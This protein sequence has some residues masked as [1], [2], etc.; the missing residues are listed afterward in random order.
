MRRLRASLPRWR[1]LYKEVSAQNNGYKTLGL[2]VPLDE[3]E[4][5]AVHVW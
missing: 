3:M 4:R 1:R 2:L 5:I